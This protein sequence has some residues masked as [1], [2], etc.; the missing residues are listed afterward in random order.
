MLVQKFYG[1]PEFS[2]HPRTC[3]LVHSDSPRILDI[4][5]GTVAA[6]EGSR[7]FGRWGLYDNP[8]H[9]MAP[10]GSHSPT[11]NG[12]ERICKLI[13]DKTIDWGKRKQHGRRLLDYP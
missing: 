9:R 3:V 6:S 7:L 5:R 10:P 2:Q 13:A 8:S 1:G 11:L 12:A 4:L